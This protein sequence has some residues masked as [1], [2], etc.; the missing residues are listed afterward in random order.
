M[1]AKKFLKH[2]RNLLLTSQASGAGGFS[3]WLRSRIKPTHYERLVTLL[4]PKFSNKEFYGLIYPNARTTCK[5][6]S[7]NKSVRFVSSELRYKKYCSPAC[8]WKDPA[9]LKLREKNELIR[10]KGKYTNV[11]QR[12]NIRKTHSELLK[13]EAYKQGM[14]ERE[15]IRSG[16]LYSDPRSRPETIV[17]RVESS[18]Q[19]EL[20]KSNGTRTNS[21]QRKSVRQK[22]S[23]T[24]SSSDCQQRTRN[25]VLKSTD[26]RYTNHMQNPEVQKKSQIKAR[27]RYKVTYKGNSWLVQGYE[28]AAIKY[29]VDN[30]VSADSLIDDCP[31]FFYE[32]KSKYG[33]SGYT[34]DLCLVDKPK[35]MIE[36]KSSFTIKGRGD[37]TISKLV[38]AKAKGVTAKRYNILVLVMGR[39]KSSDK[40]QKSV[41]KARAPRTSY[42]IG[43]IYAT[44][45]K[46][47]FT[48]RTDFK[49]LE[50][51]VRSYT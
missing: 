41:A 12:P 39:P 16:G 1:K 38:L 48:L 49:R 18:R 26:G 23:K 7:C 37:T 14:R 45:N 22:I 5:S 15:L 9:T 17:K 2:V 36:V 31:N 51:I 11:A 47:D 4:G 34:P 27:T 46:P 44:Y 50:K 19:N 42:P 13:T 20:I 43:Y 29:L 30:G 10:S 25:T 35:L 24:V 8:S 3:G 21:S 40:I 32:G 28:D 33:P 6:P